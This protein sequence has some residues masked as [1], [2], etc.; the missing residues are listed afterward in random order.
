MLQQHDESC[1]IP[2]PLLV[3]VEELGDIAEDMAATLRELG[4]TDDAYFG[5]TFD[6]TSTTTY[7]HVREAHA[8]SPQQWL[9][10]VSSWCQD[11][12]FRGNRDCAL[13]CAIPF[14]T[15]FRAG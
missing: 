7:L 15:K 10:A 1:D 5:T 11:L 3:A 14:Q 9:R 13:N 4:Y 2:K 6:F 8:Q 12:I